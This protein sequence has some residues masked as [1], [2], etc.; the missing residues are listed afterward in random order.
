MESNIVKAIA[1]AVLSVV[2]AQALG[3]A[4]LEAP[5]DLRI[6][7]DDDKSNVFSSARRLGISETFYDY[8]GCAWEVWQAK[9][10]LKVS[11]Y[12]NGDNSLVCSEVKAKN[13]A[14]SLAAAAAAAR[15]KAA[16]DA[17]RMASVAADEAAGSAKAAADAMRTAN[18]VSAQAAARAKAA[19]DAKRMADQNASR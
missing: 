18:L 15:A 11:P 6:R 14:A 2:C 7:D 17:K 16:A 1:G 4:Y 19:A 10:G 13:L 3:A 9:D 5:F 8:R 12:Q